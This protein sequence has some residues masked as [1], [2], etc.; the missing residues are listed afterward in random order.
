ML[1]PTSASAGPH[2]ERLGDGKVPI[3]QEETSD[4]MVVDE[5][6]S[7][8]GEENCQSKAIE[9][10]T[11]S[12]HDEQQES[13][14][15]DHQPTSSEASSNAPST[16]EPSTI[17]TNQMDTS[18][19]AENSQDKAPPSVTVESA[20]QTTESSPASTQEDI[21]TS[22]AELLGGGRK[23]RLTMIRGVA[24]A[25]VLPVSQPI[26][27]EEPKVMTTLDVVTDEDALLKMAQER[28]RTRKRGG[29][30]P[31]TRVSIRY[32]F[33]VC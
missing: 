7:S 24:S 22:S 3:G 14:A 13:K 17:T 15:M 31:N 10:L 6:V 11:A 32:C 29:G 19:D 25:P 21:P 9:A 26:K 23:G 18:N 20:L 16:T 1:D 12:S 5:S 2:E 33:V 28:N 30:R 4:K 27:D 8:L